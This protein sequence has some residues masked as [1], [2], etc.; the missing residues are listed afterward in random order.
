M[1]KRNTTEYVQ[2]MVLAE[3]TSSR[4][5]ARHLIN[6]STRLMNTPNTPMPCR[7]SDD[8]LKEWI[9]HHQAKIKSHKANINMAGQMI[10]MMEEIIHNRTEVEEN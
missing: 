5:E 3:Q 6:Q 7:F 2:L 10:H 1:D 4:K 9:S 8:Q